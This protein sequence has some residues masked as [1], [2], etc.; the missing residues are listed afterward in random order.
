MFITFYQYD[1]GMWNLTIR[2][3]SRV[4]GHDIVS[5][6]AFTDNNKV[7]IKGIAHNERHHVTEKC[8]IVLISYVLFHL[9]KQSDLG[10]FR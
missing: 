1:V 10:L 8:L 3:V 4:H 2:F 5:S 6:T 9:F 7:D